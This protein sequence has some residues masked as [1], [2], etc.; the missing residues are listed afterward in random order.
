[1][2]R[3]RAFTGTSPVSVSRLDEGNGFHKREGRVAVHPKNIAEFSTVDLGKAKPGLVYDAEGVTLFGKYT[4]QL[5]TYR[6]KREWQTI[7]ASHFLLEPDRDYELRTHCS[8]DEDQFVLSCSFVSACGRYAFWRLV[9]RQAPEA[10]QKLNGQRERVQKSA[11]GFLGSNWNDEKQTTFVMSALE[12][13]I[14]RT[15]ENTG[16]VNRLLQLFK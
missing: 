10:E 5:S 2:A 14:Q 13:Q 7:L 16:L 1:M 8:I 6:A 9:N 3:C 11:R 15:D 12:E 4:D